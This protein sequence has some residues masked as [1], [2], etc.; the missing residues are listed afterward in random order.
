MADNDISR[1]L[2]LARDGQPGRLGAVFEALYP[3]LRRLAGSRMRGT[4]STITPTVLVHELFLRIGQGTP[5]SVTD[6][7]HFFAASARAMRWIL[8]E[9]ARQ[10]ATDKRGGGQVMLDLDDAI[11][12]APPALTNVLLLDQG[13]EALEAISPQRR[14][15]VEMRYFAGMEFAEIARLLACSERTVY[16]EWER[17]RAFLQALLEDAGDGR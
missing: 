14:R 17:A 7:D 1:L 6:R 9:H 11:P 2:E 15:I 16:R 13:L 12:D 8:V 10:R 3:E 4:E 5:L